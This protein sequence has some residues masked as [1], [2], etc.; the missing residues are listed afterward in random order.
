MRQTFRPLVGPPRLSGPFKALSLIYSQ[1]C[2]SGPGYVVSTQMGRQ[3]SQQEHYPRLAGT[4]QAARLT[5]RRKFQD[6]SK[7]TNHGRGL[8]TS[9][10]PCQ[11]TGMLPLDFCT[12]VVNHRS[13][14]SKQLMM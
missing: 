5:L 11:L 10:K 2:S 6:G 3:A 14:C 7:A 9:R 4:V 8:F 13:K 12:S 1:S